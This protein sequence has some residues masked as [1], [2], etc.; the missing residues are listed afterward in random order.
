MDAKYLNGFK[1][2]YINACRI[3]PLVAIKKKKKGQKRHN[4]TKVLMQPD[5]SEVPKLM[6][7]RNWVDETG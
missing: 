6:T 4:T 1:R 5:A 3:L 7:A 2:D